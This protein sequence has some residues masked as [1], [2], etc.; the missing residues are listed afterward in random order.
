[1]HGTAKRLTSLILDTLPP[2]TRMQRSCRE[3]LLVPSLIAC[4][5][6]TDRP[7]ITD[8]RLII[9]HPPGD[10]LQ[11]TSASPAHMAH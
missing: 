5:T 10:P 6:M 3:S 7:L 8:L 1:M 4:D 2:K 9:D 11:G